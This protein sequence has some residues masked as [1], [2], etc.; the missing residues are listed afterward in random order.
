MGDYVIKK[1]TTKSNKM[2]RI[3]NEIVED[4]PLTKIRSSNVGCYTPEFELE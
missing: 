1:S 3:L 4:V 2:V